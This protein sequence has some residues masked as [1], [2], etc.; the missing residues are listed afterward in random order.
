MLHQSI[1]AVG[2]DVLQRN[3]DTEKCATTHAS[4]TDA[5]TC[6]EPLHFRRKAGSVCA[7][8]RGAQQRKTLHMIGFGQRYLLGNTPA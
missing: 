5:A 2:R 8:R 6:T 1:L 4:S 7:A 3:D